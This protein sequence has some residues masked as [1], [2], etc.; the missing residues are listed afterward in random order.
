MGIFVLILLK[1]VN[2]THP[3]YLCICVSI[4]RDFQLVERAEYS[5]RWTND[6]YVWVLHVPDINET[7]CNELNEFY[8]VNTP[9]F[10]IRTDFFRY[11]H[12]WT[13]FA[14]MY[15]AFNWSSTCC[16]DKSTCSCNKST[17]CDDMSTCC[18]NNDMSTC[19]NNKSTCCDDLWLQ[20]QLNNVKG[21]F[22]VVL[23]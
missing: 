1:Y 3:W 15:E 12:W 8:K 20:K 18:I 13:I 17:C 7:R 21:C 6:Y 23:S 22:V 19:C 9:V 10:H 2:F 4:E 5:H 14:H 16:Y 11:K